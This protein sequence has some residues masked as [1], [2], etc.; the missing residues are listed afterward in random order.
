MLKGIQRT[1]KVVLSVVEE[2]ARQNKKWGREP[3]EWRA[4]AGVKLAVLTEEVGEVARALLEGSS[5]EHLRME[6]IEV[7]AV[8]VAWAEDC[9][10]GL[11]ES[12]RE[13]TRERTVIANLEPMD[14]KP[15]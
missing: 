3:G 11:E 13:F 8:A 6:L 14:T 10:S 12:L 7:A 5:I 15:V 2:R 1:E 9:D 4:D